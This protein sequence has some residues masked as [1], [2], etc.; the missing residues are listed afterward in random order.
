MQQRKKKASKAE[1]QER[2]EAWQMRKLV[3]LALPAKFSRYQFS[4]PETYPV[5]P[6]AML[7]PFGVVPVVM[8]SKHIRPLAA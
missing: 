6:S 1:A 7:T 8:A 5:L 4:E 3:A 2:A